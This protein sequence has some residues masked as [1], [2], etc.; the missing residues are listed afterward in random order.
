MHT[1]DAFV[2]LRQPDPGPA[3]ANDPIEVS[4]PEKPGWFSDQEAA[5]RKLLRLLGQ[6]FQL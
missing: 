1:N 2:Y 3:S 4:Y 6:Q 5:A